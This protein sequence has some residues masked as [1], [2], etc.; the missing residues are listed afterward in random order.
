MSFEKPSGRIYWTGAEAAVYLGVSERTLWEWA[1]HALNPKRKSR[2]SKGRP[3]KNKIPTPPCVRLGRLV[4]FPI[5][6][7]KAWARNPSGTAKAS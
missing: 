1:Q 6:E 2:H 3:L 7:F 5:D 4:R